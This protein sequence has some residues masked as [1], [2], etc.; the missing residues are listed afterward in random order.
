MACGAQRVTSDHA[1]LVL[2]A[3]AARRL[4]RSKQLL[5]RDGEPLV[6]RAARIALQTAPRRCVVV[7]G[8]DADL[9][10]EALRGL[11]VEIVRHAGWADGMGTSLAALRAH[12]HEDTTLRRSLILGCDQPALDTPHLRSLL[13]EA[14]LAASG[15]ATSGYAGVRGDSG[16]S[17]ARGVERSAAVGRHR[18][19][20]A[21]RQPG[22]ADA[23]LRHRTGTRPG[24]GHPGRP[25]CCASAWL[26]RCRL[27][28]A[29][30]WYR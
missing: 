20:R 21:V 6:R 25:A 19:A 1:A 26:D 13:E 29:C 4:G 23:V 10:M 14:D 16:G 3:G 12:V 30:C 5:T 28:R 22:C 7:V 2:A 24:R 11:D 9:V 15:C 27:S 18:P 17:H 8:A